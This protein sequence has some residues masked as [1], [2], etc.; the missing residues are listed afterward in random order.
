MVKF[1][2]EDVFEAVFKSLDA[3]TEERMS[4]H[5]RNVSE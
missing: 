4:L 3:G 1:G 2:D 5:R